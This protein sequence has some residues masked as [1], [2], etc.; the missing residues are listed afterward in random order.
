MTLWPPGDGWWSRTVTSGGAPEGAAFGSA[1]GSR[2]RSSP[3]PASRAGPVDGN[4]WPTGAASGAVGIAGAPDHP[5]ARAASVAAVARGRECRETARERVSGTRGLSRRHELPRD[6]LWRVVTSGEFLVSTGERAL[7]L[8]DASPV[9]PAAPRS[10]PSPT[11]RVQVGMDAAITANHQVA[12]RRVGVD[13]TA[14]TNVS[15]L[16]LDERPRFSRRPR[17]GP[18]S[19]SPAWSTSNRPAVARPASSTSSPAAAGGPSPTGSPNAARTGAAGCA[20]PR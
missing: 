18:R 13:R 12:V 7:V 4:W 3:G 5:Q 1:R 6:Q 14:T 16:G 8:L 11:T 20:S 19:S 9:P 10:A 17:P 15:V 2:M